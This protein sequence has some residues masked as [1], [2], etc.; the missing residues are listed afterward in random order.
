MSASELALPTRICP[1]AGSSH[2]GKTGYPME[3]LG[4]LR[5]EGMRLHWNDGLRTGRAVDLPDTVRRLPGVGEPSGNIRRSPRDRP[6]RSLGSLGSGRS[7]TA[8]L[9]GLVRTG[10]P[11]CAHR[12]LPSLAG[13]PAPRFGLSPACTSLRGAAVLPPRRADHNA[14][15]RSVSWPCPLAMT[16]IASQTGGNP[17]RTIP[18][19]NFG[20]STLPEQYR[21]GRKRPAV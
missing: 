20:A 5:L 12:S 21:G 11:H 13:R 3:A 10:P 2:R 4:A 8:G 17:V 16:P 1:T 15:S 19:G 9:L 18:P 6:L 14:Y 7:P